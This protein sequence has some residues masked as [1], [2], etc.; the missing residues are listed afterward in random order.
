MLNV[1]VTLTLNYKFKLFVHQ[2]FVKV[3]GNLHTPK[4]ATYF[5]VTYHIGPTKTCHMHSHL[6]LAINK[7]QAHEN[8]LHLPPMFYQINTHISS[9]NFANNFKKHILQLHAHVE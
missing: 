3:C 8:S 2:S 6:T 5:G 7:Q 1:G 9:N 4:N